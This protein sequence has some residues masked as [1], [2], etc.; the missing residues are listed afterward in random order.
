MGNW[1]SCY[2]G[3]REVAKLPLG[4]QSLSAYG[5]LISVLKDWQLQLL[6][7]RC[8]SLH[9]FPTETSYGLANPFPCAHSGS[10][11]WWQQKSAWSQP[12]SNASVLSFSFHTALSYCAFL[13]EENFQ[14]FTVHTVSDHIPRILFEAVETQRGGV[15]LREQAL[16]FW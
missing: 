14:D 13:F 1:Q 4:D 11:L 16:A 8:C 9:L 6:L 10:R 12:H 3:S 7:P 2:S 5:L 15:Y